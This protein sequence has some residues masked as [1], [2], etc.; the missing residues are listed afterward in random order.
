MTAI[1]TRGR[2]SLT[3]AT[4]AHRLAVRGPKA[5]DRPPAAGFIDD[6][7]ALV[8]PVGPGDPEQHRQPAD[9]PEPTLSGE[10]PSKDERVADAV[11]VTSGLLPH[12]VHVH[13]VTISDTARKLH[14]R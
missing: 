10:R 12:A 9:R 13:L 11:E 14:A 3:A 6:V 1:T 5:R 8:L 7:D 2:R 4:L